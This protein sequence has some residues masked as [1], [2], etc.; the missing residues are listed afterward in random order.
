MSLATSFTVPAL[1]QM[2]RL[3]FVCAIC[4]FAQ[5]AFA[6][7]TRVGTVIENTASIDFDL[8]GTP[9]TVQSNTTTIVVAERINVVTTLQ[10][11][12]ALVSPSDASQALLFTVTNTG[13]GVETLLLSINSTLAG[14]DFDPL[15]TVPS[16]YFDTDASGDFN[17]GDQAYVPGTND[18]VMDPDTSISVFIVND[19]PVAVLNGQTG[20]SELTATAATGSGAAGTVFVGQ[21][22]AGADAVI[23]TTGGS[24]ADTGEYL[25][26]DVLINLAKAQVVIDPFGGSEPI[27]GATLTY[28]ITA[29]VVSAGVATDSTI[30]DAI[31][32]FTTYVP[33]SLTLN[34]VAMSDATDADA[35]ELDTSGAPTVVVR[36]GN[37]V[38]ADGVQAVVFDVTID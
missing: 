5:N 10:S 3:L 23:G 6:E 37:L 31:P 1:Y 19:I 25:V 17:A 29:E 30:R 15:P 12:Q 2:Q 13:N 32:I 34:G 36:L 16:I 11:P 38:Q 8:A 24:S 14:D 4:A 27:P 9:L 7:G 21:G 26:S 18:P 33:A 35:G 28:T 20:Q 22:D